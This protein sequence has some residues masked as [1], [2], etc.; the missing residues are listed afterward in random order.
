[1]RYPLL[2]ATLAAAACGCWIATRSPTF[3]QWKITND[4]FGL[5]V[6]VKLAQWVLTATTVLV[7][8][9]RVNDLVRTAVARSERLDRVATRVATLGATTLHHLRL[10][11]PPVLVF[12]V[13]FAPRSSFFMYLVTTLLVWVAAWH[14]MP[15]AHRVPFMLA[16]ALVYYTR[17]LFDWR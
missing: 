15:K 12:G 4:W 3:E 16:T 9:R 11:V 6:L 14:I 2:A 13:W 7:L 1:M 8:A 10:V 5:W 17:L